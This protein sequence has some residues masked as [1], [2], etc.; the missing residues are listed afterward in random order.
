VA[1]D[2][3]DQIARI[4]KPGGELSLA[5]DVEEYFQSMLRTMAAAAAFLREPDP[6]PTAGEDELDY[7]T[8]FERKFRR[9]GKSIHR[10]RYRFAGRP[11]EQGNNSAEVD[12]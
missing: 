6:E 2:V 11:P 4:L 12:L 10:A 5:T 9:A 3:I 7:L 8:H 1:P